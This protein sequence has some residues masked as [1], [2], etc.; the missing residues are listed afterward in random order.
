MSK[1]RISTDKLAAEIEDAVV[2]YR[3]LTIAQMREATEYTAS[4]LADEI[5]WR[6]GQSFGGRKYCKSWHARKDPDTNKRT[7]Y[8]MIVYSNKNGYRL[9]HL[10]EKG[11]KT[12]NGGFVSGVEHIAPAADEAVD[13][14]IGFIKS[15][16]MR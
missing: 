5:N 11:H 3:D 8:A 1:K 13:V 2:K 10:L 4:W 7:G 14:Y 15:K 9:A 12:V 6:A 16:L